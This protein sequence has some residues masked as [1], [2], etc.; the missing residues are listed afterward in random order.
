MISNIITTRKNI[1]KKKVYFTLHEE[2][3]KLI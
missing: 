1:E 3:F 2:K